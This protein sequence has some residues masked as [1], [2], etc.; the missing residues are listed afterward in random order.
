MYLFAFLGV[1]LLLILAQKLKRLINMKRIISIGMMAFVALMSTAQTKP[2]SVFLTA[3]QSN[4]DGRV[5]VDELPTYLRNGYQYLNYA[6]VTSEC[7]G[8]FSSRTFEAGTRYA[9][10][11]ITNYYIEKALQQ[12][13]YAVKCTYGGTAIATGVTADKLPVWYAGEPWISENNA[14][15]GDI[16]TGKS[17]T[18]SLTEGFAQLVDVTLSKLEQGYDVKA[19]VASGR[20]RPQCGECLL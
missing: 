16:T 18:K 5:Y 19:I 11:D 4:A 17:L 14:Y 13:F 6:N 20:E 15:R 2:A 12:P 3:G 1:F 8:R 7:N 9:F 10:C